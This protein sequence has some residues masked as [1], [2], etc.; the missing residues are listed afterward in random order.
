MVKYFV[1]QRTKTKDSEAYA[2]AET[3]KDS[4]T[5]AKALYHQVL[6]SIYAND[7]IEYAVVKI[8]NYYGNTDS[9]EIYIAP[10]PEPE[11]E[12]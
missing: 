9:M 5:E 3:V 6:S 11:P 7:N 1:V 2:I 12:P 8:D 4:L 10:T